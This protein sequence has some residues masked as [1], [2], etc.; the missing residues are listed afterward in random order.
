MGLIT[1][2]RNAMRLKSLGLIDYHV[3]IEFRRFN[4]LSCSFFNTFDRIIC[5]SNVY[6]LKA[7]LIL[8]T[9]KYFCCQSVRALKGCFIAISQLEFNAVLH[10]SEVSLKIIYQF[11]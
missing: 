6:C 11:M 5:I 7:T 4:L 3:K 10:F 2:V 9:V 1:C 8:S